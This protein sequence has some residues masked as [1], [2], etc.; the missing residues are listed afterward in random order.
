F[1]GLVT[2]AVTGKI[3][4]A[5]SNLNITRERAEVIDFSDALFEIPVGI[6]VKAP[7]QAQEQNNSIITHKSQ[8]NA[9]VFKVGVNEGSAAVII[10]E[11]ELPNANLVYL[12]P[13]DAYE[14]V[15]RGMIDAYIF[16]RSNLEIAIKQGL[17]GV[18]LLD[19]N[20]DESV[21]IAVGISR[22][23]K[24]KDLKDNINKFVAEIKADGTLNDISKRWLVDK[25]YKMP[26]IKLNKNSNKLIIGTV[27]MV[28]P[29]TFY[30]DKKLS[31]LDIEL[32]YRFAAWLDADIEFKIYDFAGLIAALAAGKVDLAMSN[33]NIT[34]EREEVIDF[35][36][37][38]FEMPVGILVK[39]VKYD[40]QAQIT[41]KEQ[42][43]NN[44]IRIGVNETTATLEA[45]KKELPNAN[46]VYMDMLHGYESVAQG[47]IDA[48]AY[49]RVQMELAIKNGLKGVRLLDENF[50]ETL[51]VAV[52]I[53][54]ETKIKDLRDK[55]N[56]FLAEIRADGTFQDMRTRWVINKDYNMPEIK[57]N[58]ENPKEHLRVG[59]AGMIPPFSF[60]KDTELAGFDIELA[61]RFAAWLDADI[62]FK[63]Y[64]FGGIVAAAAAGKID[65]I[66]SNLQITDDNKDRIM[67]S[68]PLDEKPSGILVK[69][70]NI[71]IAETEP[72]LKTFNDLNNKRVSMLT[73]APF[74]D[75]VKSKAPGVKDFTYFNSMAD[76]TQALKSNKTD[77]ILINN[78]VLQLA[79]NKNPDLIMFPESLQSG[80]F[81]I[82]FNKDN[83]NL[84][85][86]QEAFN[87]ID[88]AKIQA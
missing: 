13:Q 54:H 87:K 16:E 82:A 48:Y 31:G 51:K 58:L 32:A 64:D 65:C 83:N 49:E 59:T 46:I 18:R 24:I 61:Y 14:A 63:I 40:E 15:K 29:Y 72:E 1:A 33:L 57:L 66:M 11:N 53:S 56:K 47:K 76:L 5:M 27:G 39:A 44:K 67:F 3:D 41:R 10:T 85:L 77:A 2:A 50:D 45:V 6:L 35:S 70:N 80:A 79:V 25:N 62:E 52:G 36:T 8:L 7:E 23:T 81:G 12:A 34:R 21:K 4:L 55:F 17:K 73:G 69:D 30:Q 75:L 88:K 42:L 37:P 19:N 43:N 9:K 71:N 86:W 60:Y 38:L 68:D 74:A 84:K 28:E 22:K 26:D 20:M 78:A